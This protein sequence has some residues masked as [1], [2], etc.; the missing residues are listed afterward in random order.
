VLTNFHLQCAAIKKYEKV[1]FQLSVI[2]RLYWIS[3]T[4]HKILSTNFSLESKYK[5]TLTCIKWFYNSNM[6]MDRW[7][8]RHDPPIMHSFNTIYI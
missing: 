4:Q 1:L 6:Q 8:N 5:I 3:M 7:I 2:F